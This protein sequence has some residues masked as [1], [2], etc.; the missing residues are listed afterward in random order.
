LLL[1]VNLGITIVKW[2]TLT[3]AYAW[4]LRAF[5]F[6][7]PVFAAATIPV[8]S[9]LVGYV[10]VSVGGLGTTEWTAVAL[11]GRVGVPE[12]TVLAVYLF[13]RAVLIVLAAVLLSLGGSRAGAFEEPT[14]ES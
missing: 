4:A 11:F 7:A 1:A 8:I 5:G 9:S 6:E 13:L 14:C 3:V 10:P 2:L 12:A